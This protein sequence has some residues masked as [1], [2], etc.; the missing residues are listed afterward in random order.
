MFD[1]VLHTVVLG[2]ASFSLV[3]ATIDGDGGQQFISGLLAL[4]SAIWLVRIS[5]AWR[6]NRQTVATTRSSSPSS[7]ERS[8]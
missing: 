5:L 3:Q 7:S 2:V 6:R 4:T 8:V 1:L